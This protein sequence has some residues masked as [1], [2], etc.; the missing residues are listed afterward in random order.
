MARL[1]VAK[2]RSEP[3]SERA[4]LADRI[5]RHRAAL[6][7][8]EKLRDARERAAA[9][10]RAAKEDVRSAE[11]ALDRCD[12]EAVSALIGGGDIADEAKLRAEVQAAQQRLDTLR[13]AAVTIEEPIKQAE[14]RV[15]IIEVRVKTAIV[16][17]IKGDA[18]THALIARYRD[19]ARGYEDARRAMAYLDSLGALPENSHW[20]ATPPWPDLAGA[21]PWQAAVE[22]LLTD[23]DAPLPSTG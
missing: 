5:E 21:A 12:A 14:S 13:K 23:A 8:L 16:G 11:T 20:Q 22:A 9:L 15:G 3:S 1:A 7:E 2:Q 10:V 4:D 6:A 17:L 19:A 18:A